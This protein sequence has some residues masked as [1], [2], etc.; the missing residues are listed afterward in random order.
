MHG[1]VSVYWLSMFGYQKKEVRELDVVLKPY[2]QYREAAWLRFKEPKQRLAR[3]M[4]RVNDV[5]VLEG[6]GHPDP[7]D[8]L[9]VIDEFGNKRSRYA[10]C[11]PRYAVE[12]DQ[13]I[14][15]YLAKSGARVILDRRVDYSKV[16][17][18]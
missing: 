1:K 12:F 10:S 6:W 17:A 15:E 8:W 16:G 2:A 14:N 7:A 13:M 18:A 3:E 11:D 9:G 4:V 5:L